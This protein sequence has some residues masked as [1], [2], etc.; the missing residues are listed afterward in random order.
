MRLHAHPL[1]V[2]GIALALAA[3]AASAQRP[4]PPKPSPG[5]VPNPAR[6]KPLYEKTCAVCH[7]QTLTGTDKGPPFLHFV[8]VPAHHGDASFQMAVANGSRAHHWKFGD[9]APVPG[10]SPDDVAH[11][12]AYVRSVQRRAGI[13]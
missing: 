7:G 13:E 2:L 6:G 1:R 12:T 3:A 4:P 10:L 5:L 9:M 8:Y 11:I